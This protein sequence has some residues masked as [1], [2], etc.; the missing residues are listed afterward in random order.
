MRSLSLAT[1]LLLS[2]ALLA[3]VIMVGIADFATGSELAFSVFYFIPI[4]L[5]AWFLGREMGT[6]LPSSAP[7]AGILRTASQDLSPTPIP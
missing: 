1:K 3:S 2:G 7:S 4:G 6:A 5:A